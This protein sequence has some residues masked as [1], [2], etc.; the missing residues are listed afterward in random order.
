M[1]LLAPTDLARHR[2]AAVVRYHL[3]NVP[4]VVAHAELA[5]CYRLLADYHA[6]QARK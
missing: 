2:A 4:P 3:L 5:R 6:E 1:I